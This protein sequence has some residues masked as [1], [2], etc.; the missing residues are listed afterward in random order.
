M[1]NDTLPFLRVRGA[2]VINDRGEPVRLRGVCLGGWMNMENFI[3]GYPG[4]E[5]GQRRAVADV[6]GKERA[7]FFFE[8]FL[9]YFI[10][11]DDFRFIKSWGGSVVRIPFNYRH[12]EDDDKPFEYKPEAFAL[13]DRA[14][15]WARTHGIYVILDLHAVQGWQNRGWHCDNPG[16]EATFWGQKCFEDRAVALWEELARH[17]RH[18]PAV[19]GYNVMNEPDTDEPYWLNHFYRR[20]TEAIRAIDSDHILFLEGNNYSRDFDVLDAPFDSNTVYSSHNY[21]EPGLNDVVY[22]GPMG[23]KQ[24]D[25][26]H[27]EEAYRKG[28]TWLAAHNVPTWVGE[29]GSLFFSP[30][31]FGDRLHVD[32]DMLDIF[33]H[34]QHHW[35]IWTY[36]DIGMMGPV[37]VR[38]DSEWMRRTLPVRTAKTQFRCDSWTDRAPGIVT[39]PLV[40]LATQARE[41]FGTYLPAQKELESLLR[42]YVSEIAFAKALLP[43]FAEQFR[44][45]TENEIDAMMQGFAF[46]NCVQRDDLVEVL[47]RA[48]AK[49]A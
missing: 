37:Y 45:M 49:E 25:S 47:R 13:L 16:R 41:Q 34:Y 22:P 43:A 24:Y 27:L 39:P 9:N 4:N 30:E 3:T 23:D 12:F 20:V 36:K 29:W 1:Q 21:V 14:I 18:E 26:E 38:P 6:L 15:G 31:R 46:T 19:A 33:E 10:T 44:G 28:N 11:E 2:Q 5:A 35:T 32:A 42:S 17:Y 8:R 7:A 40:D 48:C